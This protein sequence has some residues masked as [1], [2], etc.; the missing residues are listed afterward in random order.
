[1]DSGRTLLPNPAL[2]AQTNVTN[3]MI[4]LNV[5]SAKITII[6][7]MADADLT[8][9]VDIPEMKENAYLAI[10]R[11][12]LL[13]QVTPKLALL[14]LSHCSSTTTSVFLNALK[15]NGHY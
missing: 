13:A 4:P 2:L 10:L 8:A 12:A 6:Y 7:S 15:E 5:L 9:L 14:A 1:L 11:I 3:A